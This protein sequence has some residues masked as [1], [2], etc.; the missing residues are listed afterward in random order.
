MPTTND[1]GL[2]L[3]TVDTVAAEHPGYTVTAVRTLIA[4]AQ[5]NGLAPHIYRIGRR[6]MIDLNG[7]QEWV[8]QQQEAA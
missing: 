7:F 4:R 5:D 3:G 6:V 1:A 2:R 8:R